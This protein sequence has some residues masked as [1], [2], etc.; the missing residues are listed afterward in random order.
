MVCGEYVGQR[1]SEGILRTFRS[2]FP[3]PAR[4]CRHRYE[5]RRTLVVPACILLAALVLLVPQLALAAPQDAPAYPYLTTLTGAVWNQ[6]AYSWSPYTVVKKLA[7]LAREDPMVDG[8]AGIALLGKPADMVLGAD[9]ALYVFDMP[10]SVLRKVLPDGTVG[11]FTG[12]K[13]DAKKQRWAKDPGL[14]DGPRGEA[15]FT[16]NGTIAHGMASGPDGFIYICDSPANVIRRVAPDGTVQTVAGTKLQR[17]LKGGGGF[18]DGPAQEAGFSYPIDLTF[19]PEGAAYIADGKNHAIRKMMP[20]GNVYTLTGGEWDP[21]KKAWKSTEGFV[22]GPRGKARFKAPAGI[23]Y[24]PDG[25]LYVIDRGSRTIRKVAMDGTVQTLTG[26]RTNPDTGQPEPME[27]P[28]KQVVDG[29]P[30]QAAFFALADLAFGP[31]GALYVTDGPMVRRI[32][33]DGTVTTIAGH[34]Y[35]GKLKSGRLK[36]W[37]WENGYEDGPPGVGLIDGAFGLAFGPDGCLYVADAGNRMIR[38]LVLEPGTMGGGKDQPEWDAY[39]H[40]DTGFAIQRPAGW[41]LT[42]PRELRTGQWGDIAYKEAVRV[43]FE[44]GTGDGALRAD[45]SIHAL[46]TGLPMETLRKGISDAQQGGE[47]AVGDVGGRPCVSYQEKAGGRTAVHTYFATQ[48]DVYEIALE[49]PDAV[50]EDWAPRYQEMLRSFRAPAISLY[51]KVSAPPVKEITGP[52]GAPMVWVP[53]GE[54][55]MGADETILAWLWKGFDEKDTAPERPAHRVKITKGFWIHKH[56]VTTNQFATFLNRHG[57]PTDASDNR[58]V[59][60]AVAGGQLIGGVESKQHQFR[61]SS[62]RAG[63]PM[64][65]VPWYGARAY[66]THYGMT[67]PTEAQWEYA[68]RGPKS[69]RFPWGHKWNRSYCCNDENHLMSGGAQPVGSFPRDTSWCGAM[70]MAG[71]EKEWCA[72][73]FDAAYYQQSPL[74]DPQGPPS[75]RYKAVHGGWLGT[76]RYMSRLT[77]RNGEIPDEW[78]NGSYSFRCIMY[79]Q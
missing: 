66:A 1:R 63:Y 52:D 29:P 79:E 31:D 56:E 62:N 10:N 68:A 76:N 12:A 69:L 32:T 37:A 28:G 6:A 67:L 36:G 48:G 40:P 4:H 8:P 43:G 70:D 25:F 55:I 24:G 53:P 77:A 78:G 60:Q 7:R 59:K 42:P 64:G 23:A 30:G 9:G 33:M 17:K 58:V 5:P 73:W 74:E 71:N 65:A 27:N 34:V 19:D 39:V 51:A 45:V 41:K 47:V 38:K 54:F 35:S 2:G 46:D 75:S 61:P 44:Q 18:R 20:D 50:A 3:G 26:A 22:D 72:D 13:W 21:A 14:V 16:F 57:K 11:M 49:T 15:R